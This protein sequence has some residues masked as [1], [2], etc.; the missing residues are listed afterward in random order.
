M[1]DEDKHKLY[2]MYKRGYTDQ[3]IAKALCYTES[4]ISNVRRKLGYKSRHQ[5][6]PYKYNGM[7][8]AS[9]VEMRRQGMSYRE[10]SERMEID[11]N[12]IFNYVKREERVKQL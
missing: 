1:T 7:V 11:R 10:I 4:Y 6:R 3:Q 2:L 8:V 9:M 12:T 5:G